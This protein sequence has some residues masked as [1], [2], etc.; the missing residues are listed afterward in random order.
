MVRSHREQS[1]TDNEA[2]AVE[3]SQL[4]VM[5]THFTGGDVLSP[6]A[7][8]DDT[9]H[10]NLNIPSLETHS[11]MRYALHPMHTSTQKFRKEQ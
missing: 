4:D 3:P 10:C 1:R 5:A 7:T 11:Q 6:L 8:Q 9:P 2:R